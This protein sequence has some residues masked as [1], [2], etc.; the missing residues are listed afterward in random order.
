MNLGL[1]AVLASSAAFD[2][3]IGLS[4]VRSAE[5]GCSDLLTRDPKLQSH[6]DAD[7]TR[8]P[9]QPVCHIASIAEHV[10]EEIPFP[11]E[12]SQ[13]AAAMTAVAKAEFVA[14]GGI[15]EVHGPPGQ[16]PRTGF[17]PE[18]SPDEVMAAQAAGHLQRTFA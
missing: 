5:N 9:S 14:H 15:E 16:S 6:F 13:L 8:S 3:I 10:L 4:H 18:L 12:I 17:D 1:S 7:V 2:L 11:P